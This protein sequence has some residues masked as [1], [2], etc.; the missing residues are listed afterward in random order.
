[1][2]PK[3]IVRYS[4]Y[5]DLRNPVRPRDVTIE[6]LIAAGSH[7]GHNK[8]SCHPFMKPFIYGLHDTNHIINLDYTLAHLRRACN[9]VR[10]VSFRHGIILL[11][12]TRKGHKQ[13]L[14]NAT[15][16]MGAYMLFRKWIPG[17]LTNGKHVLF[18]GYVKEDPTPFQKYAKD[19]SPA[20]L[21]K[22]PPEL[23][24]TPILQ[25]YTWDLKTKQWIPSKTDKVG[26]SMSATPG[27][28]EQLLNIRGEKDVAAWMAWDKFASIVE[29]V[30]DLTTDMITL[31][32]QW[33]HTSLAINAEHIPD[34]DDYWYTRQLANERAAFRQRTLLSNELGDR[35][36]IEMHKMDEFLARRKYTGYI[37]GEQLAQSEKRLEVGF[38]EYPR[39]KIFRDGS[40]LVGRHRFD[41]DGK[42][43][44][45]YSDGSYMFNNRLY[46]REGKRYDGERDSFTFSDGSE[47]KFQGEGLNRKLFVVI[48]DKMYDVTST[49][50][51][52][53]QKRE[54]LQRADE[55]L[56]EAST[57]A[58]T[59]GS[60]PLPS[61]S[62]AE[63]NSN[64]TQLFDGAETAVEY[65]YPSEVTE[66]DVR[67]EKEEGNL[68]TDDHLARGSEMLEAFDQAD[69]DRLDKLAREQSRQNLIQEDRSE[70]ENVPKLPETPLD[71][72]FTKAT[73]TIRPDLIIVLNPR[74]NRLALQ[75]SANN[76][77]P[78]IG[79]IDTDCDPRCVTY[80]IPA[81]DDSLR[82]IEFIMGVLSRAGEEGQIHRNRYAE[83]FDFQLRRAK[84]LLTE[85]SEDCK[86]FQ[87]EEEVQNP[88]VQSIAEKYCKLY[89][90]DQ[91]K[92]EMDTLLKMAAQHIIMAQ[93]EIM[94]L[95]KDTTGWSMQDFLD[96]VKTST[97]FPGTPESVLQEMAQVQLETSR[98]AWAESREKVKLRD[99]NYAPER[100]NGGID[101]EA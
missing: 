58:I 85:S 41:K 20:D 71:N 61:T 24:N 73:S 62:F 95:R 34:H 31:P 100:F 6:H 23:E 7:I 48:Q 56:K 49:I 60:D 86:V 33:L 79:I 28:S 63:G 39:V 32:Q 64:L 35:N 84:Q 68:G 26:P 53:A 40:A 74:E 75:E 30:A 88:R 93:N 21:L 5:R 29:G 1:M 69:S 8:S 4:P 45:Q 83:Q 15:D 101:T 91:S 10:E 81:N 78:T 2:T 18:R 97:Q 98:E 77:I 80:S 25:K 59:E 87:E 92:T 42:P 36:P 22:L 99:I 55:Y 57:Q 72:L 3:S 46:D 67:E 47:L 43:L 51:G 19:V 12:G 16:R 13:I 37:R 96:H 50:A 94:R 54:I 89:G 66:E 70:S 44:M 65:E 11:I 27:H 17:T 14:I 9:L 90:L 76:Q 38:A 82:S 52:S